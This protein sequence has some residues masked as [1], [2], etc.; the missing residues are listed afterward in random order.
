MDPLYAFFT[1]FGMIVIGMAF[2]RTKEKQ[3]PPGATM[4]PKGEPWEGVTAHQRWK[5]EGRDHFTAESVAE[6]TNA[7]WGKMI[8][9]SVDIRYSRVYTPN[10]DEGDWWG[11]SG[12]DCKSYALAFKREL[13]RQGVDPGAVRL[14]TCK[15]GSYHAVCLV[16][17]TDGV[18]SL[19][20]RLSKPTPWEMTG[21]MEWAVEGP[22]GSWR[23]L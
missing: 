11:V 15:G 20:N 9:A 4:M 22:Y 10:P 17:T 2:Y 12:F 19:D 6:M 13:I 14:A 16:F 3:A 18:Y 23:L 7:L 8:A 1:F 5:Q 21:Y